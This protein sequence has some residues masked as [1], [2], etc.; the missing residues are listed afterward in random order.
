MINVGPS[1]V[2]SS[3]QRSRR[4]VL[5]ARASRVVA[6]SREVVVSPPVCRCGL[7]MYL[8]EEISGYLCPAR[9]DGAEAHVG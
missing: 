2:R 7:C 5:A 9:F 3:T 4:Y 6:R 8:D 1:S